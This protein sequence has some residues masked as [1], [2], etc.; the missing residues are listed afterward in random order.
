MN[1][2]P[3]KII[4]RKKRVSSHSNKQIVFGRLKGK[5]KLFPGFDAPLNDFKEYEK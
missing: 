5:I 1:I 2:S 4:K 3:K